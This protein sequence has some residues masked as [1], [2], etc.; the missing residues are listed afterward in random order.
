VSEALVI[1]HKM[2]M[3]RIIFSSLAFLVLLFH[4]SHKWHDF[5]TQNVSFD[6]L[7]TFSLKHFSF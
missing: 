3:R 6:F 7:Q 2:R 1:Q 5:R 4:I